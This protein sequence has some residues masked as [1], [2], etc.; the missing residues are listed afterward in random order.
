MDD[1]KDKEKDGFGLEK[2]R[3]LA[4]SRER[5]AEEGGPE[6]L[7]PPFPYRVIS[8]DPRLFRQAP[9]VFQTPA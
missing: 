8:P 7:D 4:E 2:D 6:P 9:D 1:N 5:K 3:R